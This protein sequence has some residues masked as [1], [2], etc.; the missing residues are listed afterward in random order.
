MLASDREANVSRLG[1]VV[2]KKAAGNAVQRNRVRRLLK[3]TF[4]LAALSP[5]VDVVVIA[6]PPV[7][8]RNNAALGH[9][10]RKL[11]QDLE[12]KRSA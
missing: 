11:W 9:L 12:R 5:G 6:R 2:S 10:L 4:R 8:D 3:E 1:T 7:R